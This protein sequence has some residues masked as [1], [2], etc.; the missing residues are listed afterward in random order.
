MEF[1]PGSPN[2][3][4]KKSEPIVEENKPAEVSEYSK[5]KSSFITRYK[6][7]NSD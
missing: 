5:K 6:R 3:D 1:E 4:L 2:G 7:Y